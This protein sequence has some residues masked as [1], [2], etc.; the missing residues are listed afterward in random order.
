MITS[1]IALVLSVAT[2]GIS[3]RLGNHQEYV[4]LPG[5]LALDF[6]VCHHPVAS[7]SMYCDMHVRYLY[8]V[9]GETGMLLLSR[10][11]LGMLI[12]GA[13][14]SSELH[15]VYAQY[16]RVGEGHPPPPSHGPGH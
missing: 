7:W 9:L 14:Q 13:G 5:S 2:C 15:V 8:S 1:R 10:Q 16:C 4:S 6:P 11:T 3:C 12:F